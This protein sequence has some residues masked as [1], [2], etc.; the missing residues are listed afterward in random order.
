MTLYPLK[1]KQTQSSE[2]GF[3]LIELTITILIIGILTAIAIPIYL[4]QQTVAIQA[5]VET[6]TKNTAQSLSQWQ[7]QQD[8][9]NAV[10]SAAVFD[11]QIKITSNPETSMTFT[12]QNWGDVNKAQFCIQ[13]SQTIGGTP[14]VVY[15]SL[16][17]K[18]LGKGT[19]P[20]FVQSTDQNYG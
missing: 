6:D 11:S 15:Y 13:G 8:G 14:Y 19:C 9:F 3:S 20:A 1:N 16:T 4:A 12:T 17:T 7:G 10:P 18:Q 2:D 5:Q